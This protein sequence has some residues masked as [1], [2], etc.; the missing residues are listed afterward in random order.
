MIFSSNGKQLHDKCSVCG[1]TMDTYDS[2]QN[3]L[4]HTKIGYGS[5]YDGE[6]IEIRL[7]SECMDKFIDVCKVKPF[8]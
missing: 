7:C 5:K 4:I 8:K 6:E 3:F 2:K 1:K